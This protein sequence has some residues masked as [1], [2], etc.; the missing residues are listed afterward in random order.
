MY[1]L[2]LL[3]SVRGPSRHFVATQQSGR[4][5]GEA[6]IERFSVCAEPVA[7]RPIASFPGAAFLT[8]HAQGLVHRE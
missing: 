3:T 6:D 5:R 4:Y 2:H 8:L 1:L 7:F